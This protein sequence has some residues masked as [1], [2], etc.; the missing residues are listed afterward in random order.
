[1]LLALFVIQ[2]RLA[3]GALLQRLLG[4]SN[5][6]TVVALAVE[7]HHLQGREGG[8]GVAVGKAG[9][10]PEHLGGDV[11]ADISKAAGIVQRAGEQLGQV[12]LGQALQHKHLAAGEQ[13]A[14]YLK[15]GVLSGG[16]DEDDAALL[17][18]GEEGVLLG[19]VEAVNLVD[20]DDG[21]L[22]VA[23]VVLRLLHH[24]ANLLDAAG[25]GRE[26]DEFGP[27]V[28]GDHPGKAGFAHPRRPPED[29]RGDAVALN[30]AA[31]HLAGAQQVLL[32]DKF[33]Q[34]LR[35]HPGS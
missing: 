34:R 35:P 7:H 14:V 13:R 22:A 6:F 12:L 5:L 11:D 1:M 21:A 29:H 32:P 2:Q 8:A 3:G 19:L 16:A 23:A 20:K 18:K 9:D 17:H 31:Q 10:G 15:G 28:V 4:D 27:G 33:V 30:Q 26:V 25:D 24:R